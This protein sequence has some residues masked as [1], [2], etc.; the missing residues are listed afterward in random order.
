MEHKNKYSFMTYFSLNLHL[1]GKKEK[2]KNKN[3]KPLNK[4]IK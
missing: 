1:V 4:L 2:F 3:K